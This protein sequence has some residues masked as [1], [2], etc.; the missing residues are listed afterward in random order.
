MIKPESSF[1]LTNKVAIITGGASGL[2]F[3]MACELAS[4]GCDLVVTSRFPEKLESSVGHLHSLGAEVLPISMDQCHYEEVKSMAEQAFQWKGHIDILINNA[5]GGSGKSEGDL[6][7]RDPNDIVN[8]ITTN[9]TGAL[10]CCKA[11]GDYMTRQKSGKIINIGSIAGIVGRDR[12]MYHDN[13]KSEQPIDY[14]AAKAGVIGMT[15]D[16]AAYLAPFGI[17]VNCISPGG[18]QGDSLPQG[19]VDAYNKATAMGRM[20]KMGVDIKGTAL[21]LSSPASDYMTGQNIV[22]DGGFTIFK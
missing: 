16:L 14:A 13:N 5:G 6:F 12:R 21:F 7:K 1:D 9:L 20:G 17:S 4:A 2:G 19:F 18:F 22:L 3:D 11:V 15:R 10:Y 8:L